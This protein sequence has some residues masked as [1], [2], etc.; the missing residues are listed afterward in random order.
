MA[1]LFRGQP[2]IA[3]VLV[4]AQRGRYGLEHPRSG[5]VILIS[6]PRSWQAYYWWLSDDRR[7][8]VRPHGRYPPQAGL[9]SGG[10]ALRSRHEKHPARC[11]AGRRART[12]PRRSTDRSE[13]VLL[14][15]EPGLFPG[16]RVN[17]TDV[18]GVVLRH[19]GLQ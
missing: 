15:S 11:R 12:A 13:S 10:I 2:G 1:E 3:E 6:T 8:R 16:P 14:A 7:P 18:F 9:R 19:F 5:E 17:D 4:G